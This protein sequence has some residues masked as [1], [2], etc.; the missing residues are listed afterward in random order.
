MSL[1][2]V[3]LGSSIIAD[4]GGALRRDGLAAHCATLAARHARGERFVL[5]S[6]GA[7]ARGVEALKLPA[8]PTAIDA[9]QAASAVG[10]GRLFRAWDDLLDGEGL[11]AAQVLLTL[12]DLGEREA[13]VNARRTLLRLVEYGAVPVI[14]ENDTTT[15][16]EISF[17][18]NDLLAAQVAML[19]NADRLVLLTSTDGL[20]TA[21]PRRDPAAEL[22]TEV[23]DVEEALATHD[24]GSTTS[25]LGTGG[26]RSKALAAEMAAAAG[27]PTVVA[28]GLR[29]EALRRLLD[30]EAEGTAFAAGEARWSSFKL[31]LR[32]AKPA[33]GTIEVDRGALRALTAG[34]TSL[35]PVGVTGVGGDFRAGDAVDIRCGDEL[36]G[37]GISGYPA[38]AL[39]RVMGQRTERVRET[40]PGAPEEAVHR[41][42]LVLV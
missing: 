4:D 24:I 39:R 31:W 16:D 8:R 18:D 35:L 1:T 7:I 9:L 23:V 32:Y 11:V 2:V 19:L 21:D 13:F 6:S 5:V 22:V 34:G 30:G 25:S 17:G 27:I 12:H 41:D 40:L 42:R 37:K 20:F 29:P 38:G 36:I 33:R 3:K 15:T 26:M 14:N 28:N 10:Q